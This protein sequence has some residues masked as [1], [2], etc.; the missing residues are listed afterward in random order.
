M[1]FYCYEKKKYHEQS[2]SYK[3]KELTG[4]GLQF[5]RFSPFS[6]WLKAWCPAGRHNTGGARVLHLD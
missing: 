1:G 6:L 3:A 5:Q 4:A 2:N